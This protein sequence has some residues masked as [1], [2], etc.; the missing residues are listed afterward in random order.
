MSPRGRSFSVVRTPALVRA[1]LS[2]ETFPTEEGG[3]EAID[4]QRGDYI[5]SIHRHLKRRIKE[6]D[7]RYHS[8]RYHSFVTMMRHLMHLRLVEQTGETETSDVLVLQGDPPEG[9]SPGDLRLDPDRGFQ[10]RHYYRLIPGSQGDPAWDNPMASIRAIYGIELVARPRAPRPVPPEEELER[11]VRRPRRP[12][13]RRAAPEEIPTPV[14]EKL[15]DLHRQFELRR[16]GLLEQARFAAQSG[17]TVEIF[18]DL[19]TG[20][21]EFM[22]GVRPYY[23]RFPL[24]SLLFDVGTLTGC[25]QAFAAAETGGQRTRALGSCSSASAVVAV[26]LLTPLPVPDQE[27]PGVSVPTRSISTMMDEE[28]AEEEGVGPTPEAIPEYIATVYTETGYYYVGPDADFE[29]ILEE[30]RGDLADP[31]QASPGPSRITQVYV[32]DFDRLTSM[33]KEGDPLW[34]WTRPRI[35]ETIAAL[36]ARWSTLTD[37]IASWSRPNSTNAENLLDRFVQEMVEMHPDVREDDLD[38]AL[39]QVRE[40]LRA[41]QE[42]E[43]SDYESSEE[44]QEARAEAWQEFV[45]EFANVDFSELGEV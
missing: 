7:P 4:P 2:G 29:A 41:Y 20:L 10:Q 34:S 22:E 5:A 23:S 12:G 17:Q 39:D 30:V 19:L 37:R 32:Y 40:L 6:L 24:S 35:A 27:A 25:T 36:T 38:S 18:Q 31:S 1:Y 15:Q 43:R 42:I 21:N 14:S 3:G 28:L 44:Y 11:P 26:D 45:D 13:R 16:Q 33:P 8:P 9:M